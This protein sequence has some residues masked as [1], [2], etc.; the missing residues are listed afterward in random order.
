[1]FSQVRNAMSEVR[2]AMQYLV[3]SWPSIIDLLSIYKRLRI[4][5]AAIEDKA[6]IAADEAF[7]SVGEVKV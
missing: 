3:Q 5:E 6:D 1:V 4:F 2:G 7:G